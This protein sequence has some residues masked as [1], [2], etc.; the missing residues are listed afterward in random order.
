MTIHT[1]M[2]KIEIENLEIRHLRI[3]LIDYFETSFGRIDRK[4]SVI[5]SMRSGGLEGYGEVATFYEPFYSYESVKTDSLCAKRF[6]SSFR[7][8]KKEIFKCS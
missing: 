4:D 2:E 8:E 5:V 6:F 3:P 1:L 7:L